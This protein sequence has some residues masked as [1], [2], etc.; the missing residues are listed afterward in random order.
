VQALEAHNG[1]GDP[2]RKA[3]RPT[4]HDAGIDPVPAA[5]QQ[6]QAAL[7]LGGLD[8]LGQNAAAAGDDRVGRDDKS[9]LAAKPRHDGGALGVRQAQCMRPGLLA[10]RW[11]LVDLRRFEARRLD[12]RLP[13]QRKPTR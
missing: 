4:H 2:R 11:R 13:E 1:H 3:R 10:G 7:G 12:A 6:T 8:R 9:R 5:A